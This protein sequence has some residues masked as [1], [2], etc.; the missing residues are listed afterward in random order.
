MTRTSQ[1]DLF[2]AAPAPRSFDKDALGFLIRGFGE[3]YRITDGGEVFNLKTGKSLSSK[4]NVKGYVYVHLW[5]DKKGHG[6][7]V[8][9]LLL[10]AASG[11][12]GKGLEVNHIDGDKSNNTLANLEWVTSSE[13]KKHS[14]HVLKNR[15]SILLRGAENMNSKPVEGFD[16]SGNVIVR[17]ACAADGKQHGFQPASIAHAITGKLQR[18]HRG[19]YWRHAIGNGSL[20]PGWIGA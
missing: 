2:G 5:H 20:A 11:L 7:F 16:S 9:R 18:R 8:H 19:L 17:F 15:Q 10:Q 6:R 13:N 4:T 14:F 12:E 3:K 1:H